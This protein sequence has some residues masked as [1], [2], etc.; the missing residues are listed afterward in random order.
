MDPLSAFR[1]E[2]KY[3]VCVVSVL[4]EMGSVGA[5]VCLGSSNRIPEAGWLI[6]NRSVFL[7]VLEMGIQGQGTGRFSVL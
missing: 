6:H 2:D 4:R 7:I 1:S 3:I 5:L